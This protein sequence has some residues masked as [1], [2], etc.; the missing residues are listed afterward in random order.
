M[1]RR[2]LLTVLAAVV[3]GGAVVFAVASGVATRLAA[4]R[5]TAA[6]GTAVRIGGL[7]WNPLTGRWTAR[8]VSIAADRG[9]AALVT[10]RASAEIPLR[11][12]LRGRYHIRVLEL[13]GLRLRLRLGPSGWEIPLPAAPGKGASSRPPVVLDWVGAPDA[14]LHLE[15]RPR[16]RSTVR[17]RLL[18]M[19]AAIA[20]DG[21]RAIVWTRGRL[22]GGVL[23]L[24]GRIRTGPDAERVRLRV[25]A[26]QLDLKRTLRL[27]P[28][29]PVGDLRG[30]LD[31]RAKYD[32]ASGGGRARRTLRGTLTGRDVALR[33]PGMPGA[34]ARVVG[35]SRFDVDLE[36]GRVALGAVIVRDPEIWLRRQGDRLTMEGPRESR[37]APTDRPMGVTLERGEVRGGVLH[38]L[39]VTEPERALDL[40]IDEAR[41]GRIVDPS[42]P[43]P[44]S[45]GATLGTGGRLA[46]RGAVTPRSLD[47]TGRFE[48]EDLALIPLARL[49][50][51]P[52][53]LH[54]GR[55]GATLDLRSRGG[56]I[57]GSGTVV[58]R[59]LK[60]LSPDPAHPEHVMA[61]K[62]MRLAVRRLRS[63]PPALDVERLD[64]DW[65]YVLVDRRPGAMFPLS[66]VSESPDG[67]ATRQ[68]V[69]V[70]VERLTVRGGRLDFRDATLDPAY[71]S[72]LAGLD[73][74]VEGI[75]SPPVEAASVRGSAL[76]DELSPL[77][78]EG[79]IGAPTR[80]LVEVDRLALPPFNPYLAGASYTVSSGAVTARSEIVLERSELQV[81]NRVILSRLGLSGSDDDVLQRQLGIP[82]TLAIALM[83][84]YR[85]DISLDVPFGGDVKEPSFS[86]ASVVSQAIVRAVRGA[87]LAPLNALG[88]VVLRDGRIEQFTVDPIPFPPGSRELDTVARE[89]VTQVGRLAR[90]HA[91]LAIRLRGEVAA[92]DLG[93]LRD[94]AAFAALGD[95]PDAA[96]LRVFLRARLAGGPPPGLGAS[97]E[98]RLDELLAGLPYP[99]R[100][101]EALAVDRGAA[102]GAALI[103]DE[104]I[105]AKR[106]QMETPSAP[107]PDTLGA[108]PGVTVTLEER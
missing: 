90:G 74:A 5:A 57:E 70:L 93:V 42:S 47:V 44:F 29:L 72:A 3:L 56:S 22:D 89:R 39:D 66:L 1:R 12:L 64:I 104:K 105:D 23:A 106:V 45:L 67:A 68:G 53:A 100:E 79:S 33:G 102:A 28:G 15:P 60:T 69:T 50:N 61:F 25:A 20:P 84:D 41:L 88:R 71:W 103:A 81:N 96:P 51:A 2:V 82:L 65:P 62:E 58:V 35:C 49:L 101:L 78:I 38:Y 4:E 95:A 9:P 48:V 6:L 55:A 97:G 98:R 11:D 54:S 108:A 10:R 73:L 83:K 43:V 14:V 46:A 32:V 13:D 63:A 87:V 19:S 36:R 8:A 34:W 18:E 77:R 92:A 91:R 17:L 21:T 75:R 59:D 99:R 27:A 85:G 52:I 26:S 40:L 107:D 86:L 31:L 7:S 94:E 37:T 24:V 30:Q 16:T 80:M 76:V